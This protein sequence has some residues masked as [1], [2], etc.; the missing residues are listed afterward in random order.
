M[1]QWIRAKYER[2]QY[3]H[4]SLPNPDDI[5]LPKSLQDSTQTDLDSAQSN[6]KQNRQISIPITK[7]SLDIMNSNDLLSTLGT[8]FIECK[9]NNHLF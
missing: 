4:G 8:I 6:A 3:A 7:Q 9:E 2:K 5:M 1:D